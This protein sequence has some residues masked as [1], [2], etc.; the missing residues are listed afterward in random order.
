MKRLLLL[1]L[2]ALLPTSSGAAAAPGPSPD[3]VFSIYIA[4]LRGCEEV[5]EAFRDE[6]VRKGLKVEFTIRSADGRSDRVAQM[7]TEAR[8]LRPDLIATWGTMVTLGF[9]GPYDRVDPARHI[10]DIPVVYLYVADPVG[11]RIVPNDQSSHRPNVAGANIVVPYE[12]QL[13]AMQA[14]LPVKRVGVLYG[15]D[16]KNSVVE[17]ERLRLAAQAVGLDLIEEV[18]PVDQEGVPMIESVP[19][20]IARLAQRDI[21]AIYHISSTFLRVNAD[22]FCEAALQHRLPVFTYAE[23]V[24]R[25]SGA[26]FSLLNSLKSDGQVVAYQ[27]EQILRYGK[28]PNALPTLTLTRYSVII[29]MATAKRLELFPPML[30][31]KYAELVVPGEESR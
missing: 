8:R 1:V 25:R 16:E 23:P 9:V 27:A 22:A 17:M 20:A 3:K 11:S 15:T 31:V 13:K 2:L 4:T 14:Y 29:N 6:L 7:V 24:V 30:M 12:S 26:L 28:A 18:L 19:D 10:T 21:Q 5:C